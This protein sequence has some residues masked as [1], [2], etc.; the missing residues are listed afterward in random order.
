M[1]DLVLVLMFVVV[2]SDDLLTCQEERQAH[3]IFLDMAACEA[4][5]VEVLGRREAG[6]VRLA[7]CRYDPAVA[8]EGRNSGRRA[9]A[10]AIF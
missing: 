3:N 8:R 7:R 2:C 1:Q 9:L 4:A 5:R 6:G 10:V